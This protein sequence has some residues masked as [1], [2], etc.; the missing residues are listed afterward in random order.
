MSYPYLAMA[1]LFGCAAVRADDLVLAKV[2]AR[3]HAIVYELP[4][5]PQPIAETLADA[6]KQRFPQAEVIDGLTA[7]ET[8]L[9][10]KLAKTFVLIT[11]LDGHSRILPLAA[12]FL[13]LKI[14]NGTLR[15]GG[16]SAPTKNLRLDFVGR[17]PYGAGSAI[18]SAIDS[19]TLLSTNDDGQYSYCIRNTGGVLRKG[20]YDEDFTPTPHG[21]LPLADARGDLTSFFAT[22]ERIHPD[23]FARVTEQDYRRMKDQ[24]S[25]DLQSRADKDG[26]V[27][28]EDLAWIVRYGAAFIRDGHTECTWPA[29]PYQ[30]PIDHS[31]FP[32]FRLEFESGHFY[33]TGAIDRALIASELVAVNGTPTAEFLR[34]ILDRISG[35]TL[36]WRA[37]RLAGS[38]DF[39]MWFSNLFGRTEGCCKLRVRYAEGVESEHAVEPISIAEYGKIQI[40]AGRKVPTHNATQ[41]QFFDSGKVAQVIYPAF[42]FNNA[43][44]RK[45]GD[46]FGQIREQ[47]SDDVIIDLRGN[48]GGEPFMGSLIFSYLS[49]QSAPQFTA[50]GMVKISP[51]AMRELI[52]GM[53]LHEGQLLKATDPE[54]LARELSSAFAAVTQIPK[55]PY[56]FGGRAWLLVDH[57]TFSAAN[58]FSEAFHDQGIGKILGYETAEPA[59]IGGGIVLSF[60]LKHS[61]IPYRLSASQNFISRPAPGT[62]DHG[63]VPDIVFDRKTLAPFHD[64]PDPELAFTLDYI[65]KHR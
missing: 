49:S 5:V 60:T 33:I 44:T 24:S 41:V 45:I 2:A 9:R 61:G 16:F 65:R 62:V 13:P 51:E 1:L 8:E 40:S 32:P 53:P 48:G 30:E 3:T 54:A 29:R 52:G 64:D 4:G 23:P 63:V 26:Q 37:T 19:L 10:Q 22:L 12:Q 14:E 35:E 17:N 43:E 27:S 58:I 39:W 31:R 21:R 56:L 25:A 42:Q 7:G 59:N 57:R 15:W 46:I 28:I 38:Q 6:L 55:Q 18:V 20:F 50:G 34:P 36:T 11:V 47:K